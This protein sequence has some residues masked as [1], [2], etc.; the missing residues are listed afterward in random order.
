[1]TRDEHLAILAF[2]D[3]LLAA[4]EPEPDVEAETIVRA[5]FKRHPEAAYHLTRFAMGGRF[6]LPPAPPRGWLGGLLARCPLSQRK[7]TLPL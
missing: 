2:L 3:R 7:T 1:M 4:A 5:Y 6:A